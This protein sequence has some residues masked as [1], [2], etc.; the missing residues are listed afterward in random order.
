MIIRIR[1]G[2]PHVFTGG[3]DDA[4]TFFFFF[5]L[6]YFPASGQ[7]V[8]AGVSLLPRGGWLIFYCAF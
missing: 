7:A 6:I 2:R 8:V 4:S 1:I 5:T 3:L